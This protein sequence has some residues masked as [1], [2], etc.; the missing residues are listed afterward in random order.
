MLCFNVEKFLALAS[1][2]TAAIKI[3]LNYFAQQ[4]KATISKP[5][6]AE[7]MSNASAMTVRASPSQP[8][9]YVTS[10]L[11]A[12][13]L[14]WI[15]KWSKNYQTEKPVQYQVKITVIILCQIC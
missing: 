8:D 12:C 13:T 10:S 5:F 3:F 1:Y 9:L 2:H 11:N 6:E 4:I 14:E 7:I 15:H